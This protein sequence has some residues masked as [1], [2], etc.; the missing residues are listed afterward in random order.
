MVVYTFN[1]RTWEA[2]AGG[3]QVYPCYILRHCQEMKEG[4]NKGSGRKGREP[5]Q[6]KKER[7]E[8]K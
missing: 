8:N 6:E 2:E 3:F 7:M 4:K 5:K 1:P